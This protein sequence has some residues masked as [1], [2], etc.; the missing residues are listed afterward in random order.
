[1]CI[2]SSLLLAGQKRVIPAKKTETPPKI[3]GKLADSCWLNVEA[4]KYFI[5]N[6][7]AFGKPATQKTEV[8]LLYDNDALYVA[9]YLLDEDPSK[10]IKILTE[11]DKTVIADEIVLGIDPYNEKTLAFRFQVSASGVQTDRL[12]SPFVPG[13]DRSWDAVWESKISSDEKGWYAEIKIPFSAIRFP[14]KPIQEW[15]IQFG[16]Y[17]GRTGEF[18]TWSPVNPN[19]G[20]GAMHQWGFLNGIEN[21]KPATRLSVS[22]YFTLGRSF[23][24]K[25]FYAGGADLKYGIS[26]S[27]TLDLSLVPDFSQVQSDNT[28]LNLSPFEV[29][30]DE[31]R[32]FF[33]EGADLF[34]KAG[35]FY[36]RRIGI[37][38]A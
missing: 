24:N 6:E 23:S 29:R 7:P 38:T 13:T 20:G 14:K 19:I 25:M 5:T 35:I 34:N 1:M 3:D 37:I 8:K 26:Q 17:V 11:R 12:Q 18:T 15:T 36:S 10:I 9:Y 27:Y 4:T 28:V 21:L 2:A 31:R 22:P 16:R 32:Q 33:T 30:Y